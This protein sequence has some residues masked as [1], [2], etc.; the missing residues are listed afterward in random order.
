MSKKFWTNEKIYFHFHLRFQNIF[1]KM[2]SLETVTDL[3]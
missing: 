3:L 2:P 1:L